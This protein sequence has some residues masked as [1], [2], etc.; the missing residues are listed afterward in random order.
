MNFYLKYT[1]GIKGDEYLFFRQRIVL[2]GQISLASF[3]HIRPLIYYSD[4]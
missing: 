3:M 1:I 4:T 2:N